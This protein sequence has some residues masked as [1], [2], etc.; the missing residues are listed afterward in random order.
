MDYAGMSAFSSV[1]QSMELKISKTIIT[2]V[3]AFVELEC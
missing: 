3:L 1:V 2:S